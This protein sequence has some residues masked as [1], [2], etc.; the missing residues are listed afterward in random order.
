MKCF[1]AFRFDWKLTLK[2]LNEELNNVFN[3]LFGAEI[4]F[5]FFS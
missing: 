2:E 4:I 3:F 1:K 5:F